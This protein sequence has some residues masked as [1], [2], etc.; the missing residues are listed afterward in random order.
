MN[1]VSYDNEAQK[2]LPGKKKKKNEAQKKRS[3]LV[4]HKA[5]LST[6]CQI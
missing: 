6:T 1:I 4:R 2:N 3:S 5:P